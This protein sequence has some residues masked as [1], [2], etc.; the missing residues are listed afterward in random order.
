MN[1]I[2]VSQETCKVVWYS[3]LF[4]R[5]PQLDLHSK[6]FIIVNEIQVDAF[7]EFSCLVYDPMNVSNLISTSSVFLKPSLNMQNFSF[8]VL[9]RPSLMDVEHG[10]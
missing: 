7:L 9:L 3:Y 2:Q 10:R 6:G 8:H 4:K 5:F 1:D